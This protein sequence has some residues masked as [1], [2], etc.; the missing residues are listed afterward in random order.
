M[1]SPY[2]CDSPYTSDSQPE[3]TLYL[4]G[5]LQGFRMCVVV[6]SGVGVLL[7]SSRYRRGMLLNVLPCRGGPRNTEHPAP[8][9]SGALI[10][11]HCPRWPPPGQVLSEGRPHGTR[12]TFA[13]HAHGTLGCSLC[14]PPPGVWCLPA[15]LAM[16]KYFSPLVRS[17]WKESRRTCSNLG[18]LARYLCLR[19]VEL[20]SR[21][22]SQAA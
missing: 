16:E 14:S 5:C 13:V 1:L 21:N 9:G 4:G 2:W 20:H 8:A 3:A 22:L 15:V 6:T 17:T 18:K 10:K 19:L 11:E 12:I 7:A